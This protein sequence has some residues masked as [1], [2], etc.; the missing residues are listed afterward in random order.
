MAGYEDELLDLLHSLNRNFSRMFGGQEV[1]KRGS[2]RVT[3]TGDPFGML[4]NT[5]SNLTQSM[6]VLSG[7]TDELHH[8][9]RTLIRS[10]AIGELISF[11]V[12][13][14]RH[15]V[16]T[17]NQLSDVGQMFQGSIMEMAK[18]SASAELSLDEYA[19]AITR[20]SSLAAAM[21]SS[22]GGTFNEL[23]KNIRNVFK[24]MD[25]LGMSLMEMTDTIGDLGE[26]FRQ[27]GTLYQRGA[28]DQQKA[29]KDIVEEVTGLALVT[30]KSRQELLKT[31][32]Q[33]IRD[34]GAAGVIAKLGNEHM[35][36]ELTKATATMAAIGPEFATMLNETVVKGS[37]ALT[38]T[39]SQM[40]EAGLGGFVNNIDNLAHRITAGETID[41][42]ERARL[43][44]QLRD[45]L[46]NHIES[47][48]GLS[49][50]HPE[51]AKYIA[52][53][54][55]LQKIQYQDALKREQEEAER[56]RQ[57][58]WTKMALTFESDFHSLAGRFQTS[59]YDTIL[60]A[61]SPTGDENEYRRKMDAMQDDMTKLG[62][63]FGAL[64][65]DLMKLAPSL[66]T[67]VDGLK[68]VADRLIDLQEWLK[69]AGMG[70][71]GA[72]LIA[73][74]LPVVMYKLGRF[75]LGRFAKFFFQKAVFGMFGGG[76]AAA[77]AQ[78]LTLPLGG[79]GPAAAGRFGILSAA[80]AGGMRGMLGAAPKLLGKGLAGAAIA[81]IGSQVL[82]AL[83]D[84]KG[85]ET[86]QTALNWAGYG[87]MLGGLLGPAGMA[88]GFVIGG[89]AG[90]IYEN[91]DSLK[92]KIPQMIKDIWGD[93]TWFWDKFIEGLKSLFMSDAS[94]KLDEAMGV[95]PPNQPQGAATPGA[96]PT[97]IVT[98][99]HTYPNMQ[100]MQQR[101]LELQALQTQDQREEQRL[102]DTGQDTASV[103][104][105]LRDIMAEIR[106]IN[107]AQLALQR[108]NNE[109]VEN[110]NRNYRD[111][112]PGL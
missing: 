95:R 82:D 40:I 72:S 14:T 64:V 86:M 42:A 54:G 104:Q 110:L 111:A 23:Q 76:G 70:E 11:M 33:A 4:R 59:F 55:Q 49:A 73:V 77:A 37:A 3:R 21:N 20:N 18:S 27:S 74:A 16:R 29:Y 69:K 112:I 101:L 57:N 19:K 28:Q 34:T 41:P 84:F 78:Q 10:A 92:E 103:T 12:D 61:M 30:G 32:N 22:Q 44:I 91:F 79:G 2:A 109:R 25:F 39:G 9:F 97:P 94:Q 108:E 105:Q 68:W 80:R 100:A 75:I 62:V 6:R 99:G 17:Y 107:E 58:P 88:A 85:K 26:T 66:T 31:M 93:V 53:Y 8:S 38:T 51:Y 24:P 7:S 47:L 5:S 63:S 46:G 1:A 56:L 96:A 87:M 81:F 102:R 13:T 83:P 106:Q 52:L 35:Q 36:A 50:L 98:P 48:R 15:F 67:I 65:T 89:I 43:L 60:K 90:A 45:E 71:G